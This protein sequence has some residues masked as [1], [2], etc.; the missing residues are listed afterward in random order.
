MIIENF[1][2]K[3]TNHGLNSSPGKR[4]ISFTSKY[5]I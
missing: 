3:N 1:K 4:H 2:V 5:T